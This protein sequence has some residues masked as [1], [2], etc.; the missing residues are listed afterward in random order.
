METNRRK[1]QVCVCLESDS[2]LSLLRTLDCYLVQT[3]HHAGAQQ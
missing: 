3:A 1:F 2:C